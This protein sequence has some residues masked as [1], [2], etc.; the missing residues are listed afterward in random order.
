MVLGLATAPLLTGLTA[1]V[2][3]SPP[4]A[5]P[6]DGFHRGVVYS[7]WDGS[8]PHEARW[9]TDLDWLKSM[10]VTWIQVLTFAEQPEVEGPTIRADGGLEKWPTRFVQHARRKGFRILLKPHVWSR[11]F[12]D[13]SKR[14]RGSIRMRNEADWAKWFAQYEAFIVA[15]AKEAARHGVEMLSIGLEYVEATRGRDAEWARIVEAVRAVYPGLLTY[16]AD[17][18]HEAEHVGFWGALDVVGVNAYYELAK[19]TSP[20]IGV[21][22]AGWT[23]RLDRLKA[24]SARSRKPIVLTE[25]G[26]PS[27]PDAAIRPWNWPGTDGPTDAELQARAYEITLSACTAQPWCRGMYWWKLYEKPE[28]GVSHAHDYTPRG[29]PAEEVLRRWYRRQ[30]DVIKP[31]ETILP[32]E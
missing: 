3:A 31:V 32:K 27:V 16:S 12:Y 17:G 28:R 24:L 21:L 1:A 15:H 20:D 26:F 9:T 10:G 4:A 14:W 23:P 29:K 18:N 19:A 13:G 2:L 6:S 11:Q 22:A 8:Y 25:V 5:W 7:S 30:A